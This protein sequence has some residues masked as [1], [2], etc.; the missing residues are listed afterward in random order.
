MKL[1]GQAGLELQGG[2]AFK[3]KPELEG[4]WL[5]TEINKQILNKCLKGERLEEKTQRQEKEREESK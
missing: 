1:G 2:C 3:G 5:R 4:E